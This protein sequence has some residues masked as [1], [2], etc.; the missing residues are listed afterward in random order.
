MSN[1]KTFYNIAFISKIDIANLNSGEG[2][3][4]NITPLKKIQTFDG[5][6]YAYVSGQALRRYIK[7][8]MHQLG[9]T[10]TGVDEKGEPYL[11]NVV[12][13]GKVE[14]IKKLYKEC[15]DLDLFGYML[16]SKGQGSS[17]RWSPIKVSALISLLPYRD[18]KD[19]L[20]RKQ[21]KED[22]SSG[23]IVQTEIDTFNYMK[24]NIVVD[25]DKIGRDINEFTYQ[26]ENDYLTD[27]ERANRLN[28]FIESI[29]NLNGGSKQARLLQDL[30]PKFVI[31]IKQKAANPF[32]LTTPRLDEKEN[33]NIENIIEVIKDNKDIIENISFGITDKG[34]FKNYEEI[35]KTLDNIDYIDFTTV[36]KALDTLKL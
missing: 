15:V 30:A 17:R 6:D 23:N 16:T 11:K 21:A 32:L 18:Q 4:G 3:G 8:T 27:E 25:T 7:E 26:V 9:A 35:E 36:N 20:T 2:G 13:K 28:I 1:Q 10:I 29:K 12:E 24:S 33:I 5:E 19:F 31:A 14:D 22:K 34:L